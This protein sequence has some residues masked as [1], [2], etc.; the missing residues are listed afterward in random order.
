MA[1]LLLSAVEP[2]GHARQFSPRMPRKHIAS[3][4]AVERC[5]KIETKHCREVDCQIEF[6]CMPYRVRVV[7]NS[8]RAA[9]LMYFQAPVSPVPSLAP[10]P[11]TIHHPHKRA[12][13][14]PCVQ[15]TPCRH[16]FRLRAFSAFSCE[17]SALHSTAA[18]TSKSKRKKPCLCFFHEALFV[19]EGL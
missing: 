3:I 8:Y 14:L 17:V 16:T 6:L 11:Y 1:S 12:V 15:S 13:C 5:E 9:Y 10:S 4:K 18:E 2:F 19:C 7:A